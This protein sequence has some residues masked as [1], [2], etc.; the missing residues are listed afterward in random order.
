VQ[1]TQENGGKERQIQRP[2]HSDVQFLRI[3]YTV[4]KDKEY[5]TACQQ[6]LQDETQYSVNLC[7]CSLAIVGCSCTFPMLLKVSCRRHGSGEIARG[8]E[9]REN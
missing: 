1:R 8:N 7:T 6:W 4:N 9:D 5:D 2:F 3:K